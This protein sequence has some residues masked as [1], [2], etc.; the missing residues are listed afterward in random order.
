MAQQGGA[1]QGGGSLRRSPDPCATYFLMLCG[2]PGVKADR[3]VVANVSKAVDRSVTPAE[4]SALVGALADRLS[5]GHI[6]LDHAIWRKESGREVYLEQYR[7][8]GPSLGGGA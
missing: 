8:D 7:E 6:K 4:A 2:V 5:V 1:V 3:M